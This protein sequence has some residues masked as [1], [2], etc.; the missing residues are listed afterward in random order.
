VDGR[1]VV[2]KASPLEGEVPGI[3]Y[4]RGVA[5]ALEELAEEMVLAAGGHLLVVH[6]RD[7]GALLASPRF[8]MAGDQG[9]QQALARLEA[10]QLPALL[11]PL[12]HRELQED[13]D[14]HL[15]VSNTRRAL[16]V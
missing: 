2:P 8:A 6:D 7:G 9:L 1:A 13:V 10:M 15:V 5:L 14:Q 3:A 16:R 12:H 11:E 4:E